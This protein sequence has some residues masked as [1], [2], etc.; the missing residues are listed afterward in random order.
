[1]N[2]HLFS[3]RLTKDAETKSFTAGENSGIIFRFTVAVDR[4]MSKEQRE[5][6]EANNQPT[7]DFYPCTYILYN[8]NMIKYWEERLKVGNFVIVGDSKYETYSYKDNEGNTKYGQT[9]QIKEME[10][11]NVAKS[12][13]GNGSNQTQTQA[14]A[15]EPAPAPAPAPEPTPTASEVDEVPG[16]LPWE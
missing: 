2:K 3:G 14:P 8:E 11:V 15:S 7:A 10:Y 4:R 5:K 9:F 6:A 16:G 1:M 13:G 12:T